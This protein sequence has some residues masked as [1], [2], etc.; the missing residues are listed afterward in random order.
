M[1][2]DV[3][4]WI[5]ELIERRSEMNATI[6][7]D[8]EVFA[9]LQSKAI[10]LVDTPN[11]V[12]RRLLGIDESAGL[13]DAED[14]GQGSH[15]GQEEPVKRVPLR[16]LGNLKLPDP[17]K[18]RFENSG[19]R[20]AAGELLPLEE[21]C[22]PILRALVE[23]GGELRSRQI[24]EAMESLIDSKLRPADGQLNDQGVPVWYGR[25]GWAGSMCRKDGHI[26]GSAPRGIWRITEK[27]REAAA[28]AEGN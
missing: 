19:A 13:G 8:D 7:I 23:H 24:P 22:A 17:P 20:R 16:G 15:D 10:P 3:T 25:V 5:S 26:D 9:K 18:R 21:Y 14:P 2:I 6:E 12:L 1:W 28:Q 11:D 4:I 27:G